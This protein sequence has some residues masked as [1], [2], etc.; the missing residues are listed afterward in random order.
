MRHLRGANIGGTRYGN[1]LNLRQQ[2]SDAAQGTQLLQLALHVLL[3]L[4]L[5]QYLRDLVHSNLP[6]CAMQLLCA[7]RK[8]ALQATH[9]THSNAITHVRR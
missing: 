1:D 6:G 2:A 8:S 7:L 4:L 9:A 5:L 3:L